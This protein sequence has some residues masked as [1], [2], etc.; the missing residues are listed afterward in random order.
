MH[1]SRETLRKWMVAEGLWL[2]RSQR[3]VFHRP[4]QRRERFGAL[5]QIDGSDHSWFEGRDAPGTLIV[6]VDDA[7]GAIQQIRSVPSEST[8]AHFQ[9]LAGYL[10]DHGKPVAIYSDKHSVFRVAKTDATTGH[11]TTQ[12]G[13]ALLE[14]NI[15][16]LCANSSQAAIFERRGHGS[17]ARTAPCRTG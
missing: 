2:S 6:A 16:I 17:S 10:R 7:T 15:E 14:L 9:M 8:L 11:Q 4:R 13:R 5:I 12:F 3:R 1:V